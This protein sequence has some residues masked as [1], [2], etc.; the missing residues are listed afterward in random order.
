MKKLIILS[1]LI[2]LVTSCQS[3]PT[4]DG[5]S[6][7]VYNTLKNND[8]EAFQSLYLTSQEMEALISTGVFNVSE[9]NKQTAINYFKSDELRSNQTDMFQ[10]LRDSD[11]I[12]WSQTAY[13]SYTVDMEKQ[14]EGINVDVY[15]IR[16]Q[17]LY[18]GKVKSIRHFKAI[19]LPANSAA[20]LNEKFVLVN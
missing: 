12:A 10:K 19:K 7:T 3:K 6:R 15:K 13:E 2:A 5:I 4:V 17:I 8:F 11:E 20:H 14:E 1:V 18:N 16:I 9:S